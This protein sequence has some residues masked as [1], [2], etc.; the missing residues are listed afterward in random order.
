MSLGDWSEEVDDALPVELDGLQ[1]W[2]VGQRILDA[3][4][5]GAGMDACVA[6][7]LARGQLPPGEFSNA[8][9]AR[10][11][12]ATDALV[13]A[14]PPSE[15][16]DSVE[17]NIRLDDGRLLVG[18]VAGVVGQIVRTVTFSRVGPKHRIAAWARYLALA[19]ARPDRALDVVTIGRRRGDGSI[20]CQITVATLAA[21]AM[22]SSSARRH[23][24]DLVDLYDRG[25]CEP[26]PVYC[27]TSAAYA[28]AAGVGRNAHAAARSA[29]ETGRH[30]PGEDAGPEHQLV[31]GGVRNFEDLLVATPYEGEDGA[32]WDE[33][34]STRFG[35]YARR[36]WDGLLHTETVDDR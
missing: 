31:L 9:V 15:T 7:E 20:G 35:R 8:V 21:A 28:R 17:V 12:S 1:V 14:A 6:S 27:A 22:E 34:E 10:I 11:R 32:G 33:A 13:A 24:H 16:P 5:G 23:L 19:V 26:L 3:R 36:M 18:T 2:G 4:L 25:M 29:W 30:F